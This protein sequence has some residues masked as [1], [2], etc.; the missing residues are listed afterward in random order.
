MT[1]CQG[2]GASDALFDLATKVGTSTPVLDPSAGPVMNESLS[3]DYGLFGSG[4]GAQSPGRLGDPGGLGQKI[5]E[6]GGDIVENRPRD[7][8]VPRFI[9]MD[10]VPADQG[11][12]VGGA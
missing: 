8:R 12:D 11:H 7:E 6:A 1:A 9:G 5:G 2:Q 3:A 4:A 10:A